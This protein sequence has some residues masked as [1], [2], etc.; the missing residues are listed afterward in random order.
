[1]DRM[2]GKMHILIDMSRFAG[3]FFVKTNK[4]QNLILQIRYKYILRVIN[5]SDPDT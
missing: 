5:A 2:S 1:M 3:I 4:K